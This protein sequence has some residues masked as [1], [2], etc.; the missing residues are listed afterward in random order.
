[1]QTT[2]AN[3]QG[4]QQAFKEVQGSAGEAPVDGVKEAKEDVCRT[5]GSLAALHNLPAMS[6]TLNSVVENARRE[7]AY[8][9]RIAESGAADAPI[10]PSGLQGTGVRAATRTLPDSL[11]ASTLS[12]G[13]DLAKST[14]GSCRP[15]LKAA[16]SARA[17]M[18]WRSF[19]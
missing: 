10:A 13:P 6:S 1:M 4:I 12:A 14:L 15:G 5:L 9:A 16:C 8:T 11:G 18:N 17:R 2:L 3:T 7:S 19:L